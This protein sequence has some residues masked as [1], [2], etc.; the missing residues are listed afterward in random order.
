MTR[1]TFAI[2]L[3]VRSTSAHPPPPFYFSLPTLCLVLEMF[4]TVFFY[5]TSVLLDPSNETLEIEPLAFLSRHVLRTIWL[6]RF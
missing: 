4:S 6:Q 2:E 1:D 3:L 5:Q